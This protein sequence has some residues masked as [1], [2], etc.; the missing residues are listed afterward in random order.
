[1]EGCH[2]LVGGVGSIQWIWIHDIPW[3][4]CERNL[5]VKM[6]KGRAISILGDNSWNPKNT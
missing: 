6:Q 5:S 2:E 1:V 4:E 3:S